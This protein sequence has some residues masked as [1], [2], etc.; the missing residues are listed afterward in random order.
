LYALTSND[1]SIG[2][3]I[4]MAS[5]ARAPPAL[6]APASS[7]PGSPSINVQTATVPSTAVT[8]I[9]SRMNLAARTLVSLFTTARTSCPGARLATA[10]SPGPA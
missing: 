7:S 8:F 3:S 4:A 5:A 2:R 6:A 10:V 9:R 1:Q